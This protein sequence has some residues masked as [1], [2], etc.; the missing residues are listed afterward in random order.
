MMLDKDLNALGQ[1]MRNAKVRIT[2]FPAFDVEVENTFLQNDV[3]AKKQFIHSQLVTA[4]GNSQI[5]F[6]VK[7]TAKTDNVFRVSPKEFVEKLTKINPDFAIL[8]KELEL[9]IDLS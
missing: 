2:A 7:I 4:L 8:Q 3:N 1:R 9:E 5:S 6:N